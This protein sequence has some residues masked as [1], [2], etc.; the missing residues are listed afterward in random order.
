MVDDK[1]IYYTRHCTEQ[2]KLDGGVHPFSN[3]FIILRDPDVSRKE[4]WSE[5]KE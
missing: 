1:K 5:R 4:F 3:S 2:V